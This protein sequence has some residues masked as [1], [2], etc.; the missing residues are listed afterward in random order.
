MRKEDEQRHC[1]TI[2]EKSVARKIRTMKWP[3]L[4]EYVRNRYP[5]AYIK[6][7]QEIAFFQIGNQETVFRFD[8]YMEEDFLETRCV[9]RPF[10]TDAET[11][12]H[13]ASLNLCIGD[14]MMMEE[15]IQQ[16][17][18]RLAVICYSKG[19]IYRHALERQKNMQ[20]KHRK[21]YL[22]RALQNMMYIDFNLCPEEDDLVGC[23]ESWLRVVDLVKLYKKMNWIDYTFVY[24]RW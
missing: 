7:L 5:D 14:K 16:F 22:Q 3:D 17:A 10:F 6:P 20:M 12:K 8:G 2:I 19:D 15:M 1:L 4:L 24:S 11:Q 23:D 21:Y 18:H 13:F 9:S